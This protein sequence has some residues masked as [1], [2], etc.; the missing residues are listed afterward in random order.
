MSDREDTD[1]RVLLARVE[2]KLDLVIGQHGQRLEDHER[3]L[4]VQEARPTVS[5]KGLL[6][7]AA[8]A[9]AVLTGAQALLDRLYS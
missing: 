4:R 8:T 5:P 3:R 6:A 1:F 9:I 2:T 7:A